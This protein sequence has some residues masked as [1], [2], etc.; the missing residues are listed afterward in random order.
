MFALTIGFSKPKKFKLLAWIIQ[1]VEGTDFSHT[2]MKFHSDSLSRDLIYQASG[3]TVN[4]CGCTTFYSE[5]VEVD[6]YVIYVTDEQRIRILQ[7]AIDLAGK[8]YGIKLLLGIGLVR[9]YAM[10][11]K[12]IA[13]PFS[14]KETYVCSKLIGAEL[15]ELGFTFEDLNN[16]TPKDIRNALRSNYGKV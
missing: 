15:E 8:S 14:N 5:H 12:K 1:K 4:F 3:L 2:Y 7:K 13:N 11:G 10:F 6:S 9:F 16:T